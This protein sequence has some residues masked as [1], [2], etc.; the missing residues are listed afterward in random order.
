[1]TGESLE[2]LRGELTLKLWRGDELFTISDNEVRSYPEPEPEPE[3]ELE[4]EP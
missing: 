2:T 4:P 3:P 1:M